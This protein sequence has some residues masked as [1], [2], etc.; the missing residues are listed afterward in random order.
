MA[1]STH[2]NNDI[3]F[4]LV[5]ERNKNKDA[6]TETETRPSQS[7]RQISALGGGEGSGFFR[8]VFW[9]VVVLCE[10]GQVKKKDKRASLD[11]T[12]KFVRISLFKTLGAKCPAAMVML[13]DQVSHVVPVQIGVAEAYYLLPTTYYLLPATYYLLPTNY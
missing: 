8:A 1:Q 7:K 6:D 9:V 2:R 12:F 3:T 11:F 5:F 4:S 10:L 13:C